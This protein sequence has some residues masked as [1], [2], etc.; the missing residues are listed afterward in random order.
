MRRAR[1][2]NTS[3]LSAIATSVATIALSAHGSTTVHLRGR[4][5]TIVAERVT[6]ESD[7]VRLAVA[8]GK[9][10]VKAWD[11]VGDLEPLDPTLAKHAKTAE[12]LWRA[13]SR[14]QRG[15]ATMARPLFE[16]HFAQFAGQT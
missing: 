2:L 14:V 3:L 9:E 11:E 4:A 1:R 10:I 13:R 15:D 7:K 8:G 12:D 6:F 16:E 5:E